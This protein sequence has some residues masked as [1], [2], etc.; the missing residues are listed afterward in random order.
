MNSVERAWERYPEWLR[1]HFIFEARMTDCLGYHQMDPEII[2]KILLSSW[3]EDYKKFFSRLRK[4]RFITGKIT[5]EE[6]LYL[7][8][9]TSLTRVH[10]RV[11]SLKTWRHIAGPLE[12]AE[13]GPAARWFVNVRPRRTPEVTDSPCDN[14][15]LPGSLLLLS[16]E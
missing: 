1:L 16:W 7:F 15:I 6:F 10:C 2:E 11:A 4:S 8:E 3:P 5:R 13:R 12:R 9:D 14:E